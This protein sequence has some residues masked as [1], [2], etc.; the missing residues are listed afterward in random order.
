ME[1]V[2]LSLV[3]DGA[4][5]P[6]MK[7][8]FVE[9]MIYAYATE[10]SSAVGGAERQQWFLARALA[11]AGWV[12][13][14]G[15][16]N[17]LTLNQRVVIEGVEFVGIGQKHLL[18]AWY[19]F[20]VSERPDWFYWRCAN[21]LLGPL[22]AIAKIMGVR[23]IF[24]AAFDRHVDIRHALLFRRHWWPLYALGLLWTD[25]IFLQNERQLSG[26]PARLREKA[27]IVPSMN[28]ETPTPKPHSLRA[29]YVAWV[30]ML[31]ESKRPDLLVCIANKAPE[32]QFIICGGPTTFTAVPGYSEQ[33]VDVFRTL[34]NVEYRGQVPP[35]EASRVIADA[36]LLLSTA[37]EEGFP[38]TFLQAWAAGTP[39]VS[40]TVDP[41]R[42]IERYNLGKISLAAEQA[43]EDIRM[44]LN[45]EQDR[46]AISC[47]AREYVTK[48]HSVQAVIRIFERC[49][50]DV[51]HEVAARSHTVGLL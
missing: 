44:L 8:V 6:F 24:A 38:N 34:P 13:T 50:S 48:N 17:A 45:S 5:G 10:A 32:I 11:A 49:T 41:D 27:S 47:R 23:T 30:A 31:R 19:H 1:P 43:V 2:C 22:V 28:T 40:L 35:E 15:V 20:I 29:K 4:L 46:E 37:G 3:V 14:V 25:R 36:A 51:N 39:V 18:W 16:R 12:V 9:E 21:H 33:F 42:I 7:I 26:L